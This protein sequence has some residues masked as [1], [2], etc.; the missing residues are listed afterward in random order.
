V[1]YFCGVAAPTITSYFLD[2][3]YTYA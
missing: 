3:H 2:K 1:A